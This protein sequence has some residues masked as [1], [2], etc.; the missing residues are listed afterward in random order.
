MWKIQTGK[1]ISD[2]NYLIEILQVELILDFEQEYL[3]FLTR[4]FQL[5]FNLDS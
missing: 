3:V 1:K 2:Q 5:E 4:H